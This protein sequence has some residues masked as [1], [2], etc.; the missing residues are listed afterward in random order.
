M[1][2]C[3]NSKN[4]N[5]EISITE[6]PEKID[7]EL[8][9]LFNLMQGSF[10]SEKQSIT[11]STYFNISLHMYPVWEEKGY[12]LYVEQAMFAQQDKPYRQRIYKLKR[13]DETSFTSS[14]YTILN[15]SLWVGKWKSPKGFDSLEFEDLSLRNGCDVILVKSGENHFKGRTREY[16]CESTLRG[17]S[18]A[19]S[20]VVITAD[21]IIS[22][23]RGFDPEGHQVWGAELGGYI[24]NKISHQN[25]D[26]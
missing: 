5:P 20:E 26:N 9:E 13:L 24:F 16:S 15:D 1:F 3:Q 8:E 18:Y 6:K 21:K 25:V 7:A 12:F 14:I 23:D 22:W 10:N 17:A 2:S 11:D 19:T 4:K